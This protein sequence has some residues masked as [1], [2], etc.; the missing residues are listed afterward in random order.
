VS[1]LRPRI[2]VTDAFR[3]PPKGNLGRRDSIRD[4]SGDEE[5]P[6]R[7]TIQLAKSQ[8]IRPVMIREDGWDFGLTQRFEALR[9]EVG[10]ELWR[11]LPRPS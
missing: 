5:T 2:C 4:H 3:T 8:D 6:Y 10:W 11:T 7:T 1:R 9:E